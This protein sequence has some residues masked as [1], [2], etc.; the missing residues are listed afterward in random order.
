MPVA[1]D[2]D[3]GTVAVLDVGKT[4]VK[5]NAVTTDGVVLETLSVANPV[6]PGPPWRHHDL[7]GLGE[8]IFSRLA[9]LGR[10]HPLRTFVAAGHGSGGVLVGDDPDAAAGVAL[11]MIDYEQPLPDEIR[12]GYAPLAGSFFDRGSAT[13][14]SATHQARQLYWMEE[15]AP[16]AVRGARWY[17]GLP[18]YW[19]WRLSGVA[20]SEASLLGAQSHLWNVA[21]RRF[22]P[23]VD[24]RGWRRLMPDFADAWQ[25]LGCVRPEL[26]RRFGLP[27]GLNVLAGGHDSSLNHYRYHAAGLGDFIV[28]STGTWIVGFCGQTALDRLDEHRGMTLNSDVFGR[29][30]A[31]VLTMGGREFSHVAGHEPPEALV[32]D[33][34]VLGLIAKRTMALPS[35]GDDGG[36]FPGSA[37]RG[38]ISGPPPETPI[39]RKALA[40][41]YCA[42]LTAECVEA[43]GPGRLVVLDGSFLRDPLYARLVAAVLPNRRVRFNM[44]AHGVASGAA[45]LAR[46]GR[47][48][49]PP[50]LSLADP[51]DVSHLS[52]AVAVYASQWRARVRAGQNNDFSRDFER[53]Y[54]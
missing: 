15:H 30:L 21:E 45:L 8:W 51:C 52:P 3:A 43:L 10:R 32:S 35:F 37:G 13:M 26:V 28:V 29:P 53:T 9:D 54:R 23:I 39:E 47:R 36:L 33:D 41:L 14:H 6:L 4:N 25:V 40:L 22:A 20:V 1:A 17:L 27:E 11:P 16:D 18:Q 24:A 12:R 46:E 31:G 44:D 42:L 50:A 48:S 5:L 34:V 7:D 2:E 49:R 38:R 19:A